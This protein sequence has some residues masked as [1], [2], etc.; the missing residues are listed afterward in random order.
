MTSHEFLGPNEV[1]GRIEI[2]IFSDTC[3][4]LEYTCEI[5]VRYLKRFLRK[6]Q[7]YVTELYIKCLRLQREL[8]DNLYLCKSESW[9]LARLKIAIR[10]DSC[11]DPDIFVRCVCGGRGTSSP[12]GIIKLWQRF[13][14]YFFSPQLILQK[15][16]GYFQRKLSISKVPM[17]V[18][19]FPGGPTF[20]RGVQLLF[21]YSNLYDLWFSKGVRTP[22]PHPLDP[23]MRFRISWFNLSTR[24]SLFLFQ[25]NLR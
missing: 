9:S 14:I 2:L 4:S 7:S 13:F 23:P 3:L 10:Y 11:A 5:S 25:Y 21:P 6:R 20:S 12:S 8:I 19:H 24:F 17:G 16:S 15:S 1:P 18:E 22:S